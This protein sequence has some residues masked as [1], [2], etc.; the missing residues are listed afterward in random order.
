MRFLVDLFLALVLVLVFFFGVGFLLPSTAHVERSILIERPA[1]HVYQMVNNLARFPEW[2][3]LKTVDPNMEF[4]PGPTLVG[5]GARMDWN[6][7][8]PKLGNGYIEIVGGEDLKGVGFRL[9]LSS[10]NQGNSRF[11]IAPQD[12][13]VKATWGFDVDFGS[14]ILQRYKG[15]YLDAAV[16]DTLHL[17]MLR[18][19]YLL[20]SSI[21][22]RDYADIE[23]VESELAPQPALQVTAT[24]KC[25][26]AEGEDT[27]VP[28]VP[29][30]RA[31]AL[32]LI[33]DAITRN[34]LTA[35]GAPQ[36]MLVS[37]EPYTVTFD[38]LIPVDRTDNLRLT[39]PVRVSQTF[40]GKVVMGLHEGHMDTTNVTWEKVMAYL[41][42]HGLK[43][44]EG[45]AGRQID[46]YITDPESATGNFSETHVYQPIE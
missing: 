31:R 40:A 17:S 24:A 9:Y 39:D 37:R 22:A 45:T 16:G 35:A 29:N 26:A 38:V 30:E 43:A 34:K 20:E 21:Y 2:G 46:E 14:N 1:I 36:F 28:D 42:V 10:Q 11:I 33:K 19:K 6:S 32:A 13:G 44:V 27:C 41:S 4:V 23:I 12:F 7:S 5:P 8:S 3:A 25:Y 15:L 18:L